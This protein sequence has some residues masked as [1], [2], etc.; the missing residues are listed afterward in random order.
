MI[1][2]VRLYGADVHTWCTN[3]GFAPELLG[4]ERLD[5]GWL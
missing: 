5:G 1:R 3:N 4:F 2:F